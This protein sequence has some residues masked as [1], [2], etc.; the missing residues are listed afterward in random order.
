M[1]QLTKQEKIELT[2]LPL[3][4]AIR[5]YKEGRM[6]DRTLMVMN[7]TTLDRLFE[8]DP[9]GAEK[10]ARKALGDL[11]VDKLMKL[12]GGGDPH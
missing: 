11:A 8:I 3:K 4:V 1:D 12:R 2:L 10:A 5:M 7:M 6:D 9:E